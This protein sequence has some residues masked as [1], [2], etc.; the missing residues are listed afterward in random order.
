MDS[1]KSGDTPE[2]SA[3]YTALQMKKIER[4]ALEEA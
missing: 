1:K 4:K 3:L 2:L